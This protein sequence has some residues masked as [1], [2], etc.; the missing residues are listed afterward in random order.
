ADPGPVRTKAACPDGDFVDAAGALPSPCREG[1]SAP[2]ETLLASLSRQSLPLKL[3]LDALQK[4]DPAK[5]RSLA[6]RADPVTEHTVSWVALTSGMARQSSSEVAATIST[7][8]DWPAQSRM[9][10]RYEEALA[11]ERPKPATVLQTFT[12][13]PPCTAAGTILY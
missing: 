6:Q 10:A 12:E 11:R 8:Q 5:A 4:G 7:L 13:L 1:V 2:G 9:R 3:A